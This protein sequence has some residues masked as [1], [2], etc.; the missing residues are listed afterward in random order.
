MYRF[1]SFNSECITFAFTQW[2]LNWFEQECI[3]LNHRGKSL[4]KANKLKWSFAIMSGT[5]KEWLLGSDS[6]IS[7]HTFSFEY[8]ECMYYVLV[9]CFCIEISVL[10]RNLG[11]QHSKNVLQSMKYMLNYSL[12]FVLKLLRRLVLLGN[13][14]LQGLF[15]KIMFL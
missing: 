6:L 5:S 3:D 9:I 13:K 10:F 4:N 2:N 11:L 14:S 15:K 1:S 12:L 7:R 8:W